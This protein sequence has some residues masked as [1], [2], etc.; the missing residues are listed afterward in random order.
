MPL[1]QPLTD[2][3]FAP[4]AASA[5]PAPAVKPR[6]EPI[7]PVRP[8]REDPM[9]TKNLRASQVWRKTLVGYT[10]A[11][12]VGLCL[13]LV[14]QSG[15]QVHM[16]LVKNQQLKEQVQLAQQNNISYKARLDS[17]FSLEVIHNT[18]L[19]DYHMVPVEGG[20]VVYLNITHGDR[21]LD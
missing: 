6:R 2:D 3:Y 18:A 11:A 10:V 17:R 21:R 15:T 8:Q 13:F 9:E 1:P 19:R 16:A 7:R 14:I 12:L 5:A 4:F 20:R